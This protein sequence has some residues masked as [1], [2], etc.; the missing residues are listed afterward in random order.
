MQRKAKEREEHAMEQDH[1][2]EGLKEL[3]REEKENFARCDFVFFIIVY[4]LHE[5]R[6]RKLADQPVPALSGAAG[7]VE[8]GP[9]TLHT[10][11]NTLK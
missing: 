2:N 11:V 5:E 4:C 9:E 10:A 8:G 1:I 7:R 3:N 6:G